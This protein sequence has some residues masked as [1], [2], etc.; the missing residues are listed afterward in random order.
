MGDSFIFGTVNDT[1]TPANSSGFSGFPFKYGVNGSGPNVIG[2]RFP[3][4]VS[5][6]DCI[7]LWW[8]AKNF[9]VSTDL[10]ATWNSVTQSYAGGPMTPGGGNA[11]RELDLVDKSTQHVFDGLTLYDATTQQLILNSG[12]FY[13][14]IYLSSALEPGGDPAHT[15][16]LSTDSGEFT[17][18]TSIPM[19]ISGSP[20][21]ATINLT[22]YLLD[23][24]LD[25]F[26]GTHFD[27]TILSTWPY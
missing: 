24:G 12:L 23:T 7:A 22:L 5:L 9:S 25:S 8:K 11:S 13:L 14:Y 15:L 19:T 16:S 1:V 10:S 26:V 6:K 17:P 18:T 27:V 21:V 3:A 2:R 4:A 20:L